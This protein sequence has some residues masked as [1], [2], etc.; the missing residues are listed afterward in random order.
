MRAELGCVVLDFGVLGC[1]A[2]P[3]V[4]AQGVSDV[5]VVHRT[6]LYALHCGGPGRLTQFCTDGQ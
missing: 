4:A 6:L 3:D 2:A 1:S 5:V